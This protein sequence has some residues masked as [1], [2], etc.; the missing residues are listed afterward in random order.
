MA[1]YSRDV[2]N[3]LS[4]VFDDGEEYL[5]AELAALLNVAGKIVDGRIDFSTPHAFV[6]RK[7]INLLKKT[8]P[9][10]QKEFSAVRKKVLMQTTR[11]FVRIFLTGHTEGILKDLNSPEILADDFAKVSYLRGAFLAC[12]TVNR[13]EKRYYLDI[14]VLSES[15]AMF[16][17]QIWQQL[18][19]HPTFCVRKEFFVNYISEGDAIEEFLGMIGV[20]E[21]L[22][23][24]QSAR[25]LKEVRANVN[26]LV[27]VETANLNKVIEAA[28]KQLADIEY[29]KEN[30]VQVSKELKLAMK[31]RLT[32]P[33]CSVA[34][35]AEMLFITKQGL[36][37]RF[38]KIHELAMKHKRQTEIKKQLGIIK[39]D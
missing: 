39:N 29:L 14:S 27:N 31:A 36:N 28:Q 10:A 1:S 11:Y 2:K 9:N 12:G 33:E 6:A 21:C 15:A 5:R 22:E 30:K 16:I 23:R 13:P 25:N 26:R 35:L 19:F 17:N 32:F 18:E 34:E 24:F 7:V 3:E 20:E 4:R 37:Y 38:N 8:Y